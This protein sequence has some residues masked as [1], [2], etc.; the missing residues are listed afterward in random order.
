MLN[1]TK[2][3]I[4][5]AEPENAKQLSAI[6]NFIN[7]PTVVAQECG[8]WKQ[9]IEGDARILA[10]L[11]GSC[12]TDTRLADLLTDIHEYDHNI[13]VYLLTRKGLE[14]TVAIDSGSCVLGRIDLPPIYSQLTNAMH[15]AEVFAESRRR[16]E[17]RARPVDLF[18]SLVGSSRA[19]QQVRKMVEQVADSEA[20]VLILGESGTGKEV[21]A[22]NLHYHSSR[23]DK[24]FVPVNCGAIPADLLESELFGHEK[25]AFTGAISAREGR[26]E[27]AEGGTL[28][29]D[30]IGD[31]SLNM[32]VK[33]LRVLQEK[34]FERVGSNT[35][36][37]TNVRVIAA[38][39][40]DLESAIR[41]GGFRED[42]YYRLNVF[43][44]EMPP[45]RDRL[46]DIP[47]LVNE[48][49]R[50]IEHERRGSVRLSPGAVYALCQYGWPGNVREL[51]N[52]IERLAILHPYGVVEAG[53]L[54]EKFRIEE[55]VDV[56][57]LADALVGSPMTSDDLDP[58]LP[59]DGLNLK[60]H[61]STL[62]V[63]YIKQALHDTGGVVAHA[64]KRLGMRRTT[65]VEKLRKYG[66]QRSASM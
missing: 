9:A 43:P 45:L 53:D 55:R 58:R 62:E 21:V 36:L 22:R 7:Y 37:T 66:L 29:L 8:L 12:R 51:A 50:R 4:I 1:D 16:T 63:N 25:G 30:E 57:Q 11:V 54:P 60:E 46:E 32:Q 34:T 24:P 20:N 44:I 59:R 13:P 23:R 41:E 49:V 27:M 18:R 52:L 64:A 40:R 6:L 61:L 28:F 42:L 56:E 3:L 17:T 38:T 10:V 39:H 26:F 35:S 19:I 33:I 65:L 47:L 5:E 31:M 15:Q 2:V 48:L 14:P